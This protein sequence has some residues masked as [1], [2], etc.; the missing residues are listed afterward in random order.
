M[1]LCG[2]RLLSLTPKRPIYLVQGAWMSSKSV[3]GEFLQLE[4]LDSC[5]GALCYRKPVYVSRLMRVLYLSG[6]FYFILNLGALPAAWRHLIQASCLVA[7]WEMLTAWL[8]V[9][10]QPWCVRHCQFHGISKWEVLLGSQPACKVLSCQAGLS[11]IP[12]HLACMQISKRLLNMT[13]RW[14]NPLSSR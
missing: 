9:G 13:L 6:Y 1:Y 8:Q 4:L 11:S 5:W 14:D 12:G 3:P 2:Q 10:E 7:C